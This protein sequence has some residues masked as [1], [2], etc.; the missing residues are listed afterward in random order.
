MCWSAYEATINALITGYVGELKRFE[1][2]AIWLQTDDALDQMDEE[3]E[4]NRL[5]ED[6]PGVN[7][8]SVVDYIRKDYVLSSASDWSNSRIRKYIDS[9]YGG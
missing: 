1:L 8:G 4:R 3:V 6:R 5:S 2:E 9:G 7:D